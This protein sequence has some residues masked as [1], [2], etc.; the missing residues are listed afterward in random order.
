M[1][2]PADG[3]DAPVVAE[4]GFWSSQAAAELQGFF[5][6]C[7][8]KERGFVTREDLAGLCG[9]RETPWARCLLKLLFGP[10]VVFPSELTL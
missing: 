8:A 4:P 9:F 5:Q 2:E 1:R 3:Q 7:G 6:D 10:G